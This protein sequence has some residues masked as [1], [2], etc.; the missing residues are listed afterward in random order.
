VTIQYGNGAPNPTVYHNCGFSGGRLA[1]TQ[2][3]Y[4]TIQLG[5]I[6]DTNFLDQNAAGC[7]H[8]D[9]RALSA[10]PGRLPAGERAETPGFVFKF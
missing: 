6:A 7:P 3:G 8:Y 9:G 10:G 5:N 2:S 4:E 1:F